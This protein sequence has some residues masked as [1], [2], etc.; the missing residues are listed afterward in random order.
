[1]SSIFISINK[2]DTLEKSPIDKA[3][4]RVAAALARQRSRLPPGPGLEVAFSAASTDW[5][6]DFR[7]MRMGG[8]RADDPVLRFEVAVPA[9][10]AHSPLAARYVQAALEDALGHA[11]GHFEE[12]GI[13]FDHA[14]WQRVLD[15]AGQVEADPPESA[16]EDLPLV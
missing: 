6:P 11:Q 7:G 2:S 16:W 8:Y 5:Q 3:I 10:L 13:D 9:H 4:V 12:L 14:G 15:V 1:M